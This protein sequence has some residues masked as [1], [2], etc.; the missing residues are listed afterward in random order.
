[1]TDPLQAFREANALDV[2]VVGPGSRYH[3][4][5]TAQFR[6][7]DGRTIVY[8]RR[9]FPPDP[10]TLVLIGTADVLEGDRPDL[11]AYR[12]LGDP[13]A[14]WRLADA[15]LVTDPNQLSAVP[16]SRVR[17]TLPDGLQAASDD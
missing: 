17:L 9:R 16:G 5:G 14:W 11:L 15:N 7:E 12:H 13:A 1:M 2:P 10:A 3:G 4:V 6:G 8:L